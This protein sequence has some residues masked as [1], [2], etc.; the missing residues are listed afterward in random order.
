MTG[1]HH[2]ADR[3]GGLA[4]EAS[5]SEGGAER[6]T[7][8]AS[9]TGWDGYHRDG[10]GTGRGRPRSDSGGST[11]D[12]ETDRERAYPD[13]A[14]RETAADRTRSLPDPPENSLLAE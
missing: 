6:E 8:T 10:I 2:L 5:P 9:F 3:H 14:V 1:P 4:R 7:G 12:D 13:F 11:S